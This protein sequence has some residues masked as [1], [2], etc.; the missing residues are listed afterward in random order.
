MKKLITE[1]DVI[2]FA[3]TGGK[4]LP[5]GEEDIVT[6]LAWDKIKA[7]D[8]ATVTK[9]SAENINLTVNEIEKSTNRKKN[10]NWQRPHRL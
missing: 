9:N 10:R 2:K 3:K 1:L 8:I 6:A 4:V 5:I 7:L